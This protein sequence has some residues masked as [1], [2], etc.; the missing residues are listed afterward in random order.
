MVIINMVLT[1]IFFKVNLLSL[2][3]FNHDKFT[4]WRIIF[5]LAMLY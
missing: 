4:L 5:G 1:E 2:Y 3:Y